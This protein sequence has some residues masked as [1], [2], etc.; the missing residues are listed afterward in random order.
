VQCSTTIGT[1]VRV[2]LI[3]TTTGSRHGS[4]IVLTR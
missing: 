4:V 3:G 2:W 1:L